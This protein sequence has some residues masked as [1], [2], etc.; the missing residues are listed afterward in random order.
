MVRIL[1]LVAVSLVALLAVVIAAGES[2]QGEYNKDKLQFWPAFVNSLSMII[3]TEIGDKTFFIAAVLSMRSNRLA[4]FS[5]AFMALIAMTILSTLMGLV[6]PSFLP[7]KYTH[8]LSGIL[9]VYFGIKLVYESLVMEHKVS[10]E[11]EEVEEELCLNG[12]K[13]DVE[14]LEEHEDENQSTPR[15]TSMSIFVKALTLT[16]LAEV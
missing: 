10:D 1:R 15:E 4:V 5:G 16:F 3:A 14:S 8:I 7:R 6:L 13:Q 11:L 9:F 12:K 2:K